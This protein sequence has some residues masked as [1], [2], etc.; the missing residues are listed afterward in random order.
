[1]EA[2]P[3]R[4]TSCETDA[5]HDR[6]RRAHQRPT[7]QA[8]GPRQECP[9]LLARPEQKRRPSEPLSR[10]AAANSVSYETTRFWLVPRPPPGEGRALPAP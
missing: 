10:E 9:P 5:P 4:F 3:S 1:M 8:V 7:H 2:A 6:R